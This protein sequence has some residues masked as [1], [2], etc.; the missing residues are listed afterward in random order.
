MSFKEKLIDLQVKKPYIFILLTVA[1]TILAIP[2]YFNLMSCLQPSVEK[3]LPKQAEVVKNINLVRDQ[4]DV[5]AIQIVIDTNND[6]RDP[7]ALK[8]F[9]YFKNYLQEKVPHITKIMTPADIVKEDLSYIPNTKEEVMK[10]VELDPRFRYFYNHDYRLAV[11][12]VYTDIGPDTRLALNV[13]DTLKKHM[14]EFE[15]YFP[16]DTKVYLTGFPA[17]NIDLF[18][19]IIFD[20]IKISLVAFAIILAILV[21][22]FR[23]ISEVLLVISVII[24]PLLWTT[25]IIGYL[26]LELTMVS[27][28]FGAMLMALGISYGINF[29]NTYLQEKEKLK[30]KEKA[31]RETTNMLLTALVG[32]SLTTIASFIA[33]LAGIVPSYRS[34]GIILAIGISLVLIYTLIIFPAFISIKEGI[35][36]TNNNSKN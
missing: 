14:Q 17:L 3:L 9:D 32:S 8:T 31:L 15:R 33:L 23:R 21:V 4:F 22:K 2:G 13:I 19:S 36:K 35:Y 16:F 1:L 12:Y 24:F 34:L 5:D 29:Y 30:D 10:V 20:F 11:I 18:F 26:H 27:T 28:V 25:G 7:N 6:L